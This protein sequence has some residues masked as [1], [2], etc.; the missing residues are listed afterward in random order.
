MNY[1]DYND[2][3][4]VYLV[5]EDSEEA[6]DIIMEKYEPVIRNMASYYYDNFKF[7]LIDFE[8]L[9]QE[10][11]MGLLYAIRN[12]SE[13]KNA[14]FYSFAILCIKG[15][16]VNQLKHGK[17]KKNYIDFV[18]YSYEDLFSNS[19]C[20]AV[21]EINEL[22]DF[23]DLQDKIILFKNELSFNDSIVFEL[24]LNGFSY[25]E[26]SELL[27]L[28]IKRVDNCLYNIRKKFKNYLLYC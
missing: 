5:R 20:C 18:S 15:K 16:M 1:D 12:F 28:D 2:Y 21:D 25:K 26:I 23:C 19:M 27:V 4:L 7:I 6:I 24:K 11:R 17:A 14:L 8:D 9:M 3:E 10:G 13:C 22:V